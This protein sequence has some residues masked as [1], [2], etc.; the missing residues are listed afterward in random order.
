MSAHFKFLSYYDMINVKLLVL[1]LK[2]FFCINKGL[3]IKILLCIFTTLLLSF[4]V[5][6][7]RDSLRSALIMQSFSFFHV[8]VLVCCYLLAFHS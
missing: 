4:S 1:S 2:R 5:F 6:L 8:F 7:Y 3:Y